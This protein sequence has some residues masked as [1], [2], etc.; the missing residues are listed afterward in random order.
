ME[1]E[2][3]LL[4][5]DS[6]SIEDPVEKDSYSTTVSTESVTNSRALHGEDSMDVDLSPADSFAQATHVVTNGQPTPLSMDDNATEPESDQAPEQE[7]I[8]NED[9][10]GIQPN[11]RGTLI[12]GGPVD[13]PIDV[14]GEVMELQYPATPEVPT[15]AED[16]LSTTTPPIDKPPVR[17]PIPTA[18]P[19]TSISAPVGRFY[20]SKSSKAKSHVSAP[21]SRPEIAVDTPETLASDNDNGIE[22]DDENDTAIEVEEEKT[23]VCYPV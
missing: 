3:E 13:E 18:L 4:N 20:S 8:Y 10:Y 19:H 21:P 22:V 5:M 15:I 12:G 11:E 16:A 9:E 6:F 7:D 1:V 23:W 2:D 14:D 17:I